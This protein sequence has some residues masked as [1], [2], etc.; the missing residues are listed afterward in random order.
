[1]LDSEDVRS[2]ADE[3]ER[4]I[5]QALQNGEQT[6]KGRGYVVS[7]NLNREDAEV[8]AEW[9]EKFAGAISG[10]GTERDARS[11]YEERE[12]RKAAQILRG[13]SLVKPPVMELSSKEEKGPEPTSTEKPK[14]EADVQKPKERVQTPIGPGYVLSRHNEAQYG[15]FMGLRYFLRGPYVSV[16]LDAHG[17]IMDFDPQEVTPA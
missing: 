1:M 4:R 7:V 8:L 3:Q 5:F 12:A 15:E 11:Y 14:K 6:R 13:E 2:P 9:Y 17:G 10:P 16:A